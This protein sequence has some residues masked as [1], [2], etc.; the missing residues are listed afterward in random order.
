[1]N[2]PLLQIQGLCKDL[3]G[4]RIVDCVDMTVA[5]GEIRG[6]V[7][8]SG[9]GKTTLARCALRLLQ[10]SAGTCIFDGQNLADLSAAELRRKRSEF[11]MVFQDSYA[12]LDPRM[13]IEE[14][15]LEPLQIHAI[16]VLA[17]RRRL[18]ELIDSVSLD[19]AWMN[20]RPGEL[21]GGQQQRVGIA[22]ALAL[23]PRLLVADEPVSALD[24]SVQAQI[25][26]LLSDL[27]RQYDLTLVLISHSLYAIH[28]LCTQVSVMYGGRIV[29]EAPAQSFFAGAKHPYSRILLESMPVLDAPGSAAS[30]R[31]VQNPARM[32]DAGG[33]GCVFYSN[34][35]RRM[36]ICRNRIPLLKELEPEWLVACFL[37][38]NGDRRVAAAD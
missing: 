10:P 22:R 25:L 18:L 4:R 33:I 37:Y 30:C 16:G 14:I 21:S 38:E 2:I 32:D 35:P 6:V 11:Q 1:M 24:V 19:S 9:S 34:C 36:D 3:G 23:K 5:R 27:K 31:I 12:A 15:L 26:N 8:E 13:T 7:G 28:Y 17:E 20:R 29:E